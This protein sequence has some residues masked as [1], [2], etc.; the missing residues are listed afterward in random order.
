MRRING[1]NVLTIGCSF[2]I[3]KGGVAQ[4]LCNYEQYVFSSFKFVANSGDGNFLYKILKV[5]SAIMIV[6][7][8]LIFDKKIKI[9]HIHTAS[10][11]S[12]RRSAWFVYV[13]KLFRKRII[14]HIHGGGFKEYYFSNSSTISKVLNKC[15]CIIV[16]SQSWK[17]FFKSITTCRR[18]EVV[19]NII[20][21]PIRL[22]VIKDKSKIHF[23]FMG[24]ITEQKGIFDLLD[25]ITEHKRE[26]YDS[27]RLHI[28]GNGKVDE[29]KLYV[30]KNR[31]HDIV[32]FEGWVS[33]EKKTELYNLADVYI[34]PSYTEGMPLSILEA[35]SYGLP[36][37]T[38]PVG[39]IP[40]V[41]DSRN[42]ILFAP[43]DKQGIFNAIMS[44]VINSDKRKLMSENS[45]NKSLKFFPENVIS[46]LES[47]YKSMFN[48]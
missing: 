19:E 34:L 28:G 45:R 30:E 20:V 47:V 15:D 46:Q 37:L 39:G 22:N 38:T 8:L 43:G 42:G 27:I 4:V 18:I 13:A 44:I 16:L 14:L 33:G 2:H 7:M 29:L 6:C 40:E 10:Y 9:V 41:V 48:E 23:L 11:N 3:P 25:V 24:L 35:M 36:I 26:F 21:P 17:S 31:L 1:V 12:F 5:S 32:C